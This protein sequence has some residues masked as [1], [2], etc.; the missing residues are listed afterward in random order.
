MAAMIIVLFVVEVPVLIGWFTWRSIPTP[1]DFGAF[2][3]AFGSIVG[4]LF[5]GLAFAGLIYTALMQREELSLQRQELRET[6]EE[7]KRQ[8][9]AQEASEAA[10]RAQV[11]AAQLSARL[12]AMTTLIGF[13]NS[14][15]TGLFGET[16]GEEARRKVPEIAQRIESLLVE[17]EDRQNPKG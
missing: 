16:A 3:Q 13:Y 12:T 8:A 1:K 7:L 6:R 5:A 11:E 9:D 14:R 10:L 15:S 2:A 4:S 17:F